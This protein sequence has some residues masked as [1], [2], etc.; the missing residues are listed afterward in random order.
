MTSEEWPTGLPACHLPL[1][2][3]LPGLDPL[4]GS[5]QDLHEKLV[6]GV[7]TWPEGRVSCG[8]RRRKALSQSTSMGPA[9]ARTGYGRVL[10]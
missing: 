1:F 5:V 6:L 10:A 7:T 2:G 3:L 4:L 8:L 9:G